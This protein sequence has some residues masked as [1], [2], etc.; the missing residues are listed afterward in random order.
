MPPSRIITSDA[1]AAECGGGRCMS[2]RRGARRGVVMSRFRDD[3]AIRHDATR[4]YVTAIIA[5][6]DV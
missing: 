2:A 1:A 6:R 5:H 3:G 4:T